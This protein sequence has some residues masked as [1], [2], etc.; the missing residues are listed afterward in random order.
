PQLAP[1][2]EPRVAGRQRARRLVVGDRPLVE[3][4][5][6]ETRH[7]FLS[8]VLR[9]RRHATSIR[10][11][12]ESA[13]RTRARDRSETVARQLATLSR[14]VRRE[15]FGIRDRSRSTHAARTSDEPIDGEH[16]RCWGGVELKVKVPEVKIEP[17]PVAVQAPPKEEPKP[18]PPQPQLVEA[19]TTGA[20]RRAGHHRVRPRQGIDAPH[21]SR[22]PGD[23]RERS[24]DPRVTESDVAN[25]RGVEPLVTWIDDRNGGAAAIDPRTFV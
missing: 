23:A 16:M 11:K 25:N 17:K 9:Q 10:R 3:E 21:A 24:Q 18:E 13:D 14:F 19:T 6:L 15:P 5:L 4:R 2:R 12:R 1:A 22:N 20:D 7:R 8:R